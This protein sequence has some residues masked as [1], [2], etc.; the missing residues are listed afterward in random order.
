MT[1]RRR[2]PAP[3]LSGAQFGSWT[4]VREAAQVERPHPMRHVFVNCN[5]GTKALVRLSHLINGNSKSCGCAPVKAR[6]H[7]LARDG[8]KHPL[9]Q[10]WAGMVSRCGD[11]TNRQYSAYG[12]RGIAVCAR[13]HSVENF[14]A[15]MSPRPA[16]KSLDRIDNDGP[17]SPENCRWATPT[18]QQR[19]SRRNINVCIGGKTQCLKDWCAELGMNYRT[20]MWRTRHG[21]WPV[22]KALLTP[23]SR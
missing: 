1:K 12:G 14:I 4:V 15:D 6:K 21:G 9:Y 20:V 7:G 18:Q 23:P 19:N 22:E 8:D 11:A 13:W 10:I 16:G 3:I 5:C 2:T 17:Y